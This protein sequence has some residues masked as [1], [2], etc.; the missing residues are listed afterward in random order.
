MPRG[1]SACSARRS[2]TVGSMG[3]LIERLGRRRGGGGGGRGGRRRRR[4][5]SLTQ[6]SIFAP[7]PPGRRMRSTS[8]DRSWTSALP[9][10]TGELE[11]VT[12]Q[13]LDGAGAD[14]AHGAD[15]VGSEPVEDAVDAALARSTEAVQV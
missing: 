8:V 12:I 3:A 6:S 5:K 2:S 11:Q 10:V 4:Q 13:V 1:L 14:Q 9:L 7:L 15:Q